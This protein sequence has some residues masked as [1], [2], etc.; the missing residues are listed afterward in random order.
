LSIALAVKLTVPERVA[1]AEGEIIETVGGVVSADVEQVRSPLVT[2]LLFA[3]VECTRQWYV[4]PG[5][6]FET[7]T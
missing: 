6:R 5:F 1:L 2:E 4:L 7:A 3:S